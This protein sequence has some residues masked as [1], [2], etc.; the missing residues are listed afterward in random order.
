MMA[1]TSQVQKLE[2]HKFFKFMGWVK[3][4]LNVIAMMLIVLI[5]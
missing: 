5:L 1:K 2:V 3:S 4:D